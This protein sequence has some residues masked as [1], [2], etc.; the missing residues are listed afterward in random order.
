MQIKIGND[1]VYIPKFKK[2]IERTPNITEKIFH[3]SEKQDNRIETLAGIF[4]AKESVIK[5]LDLEA[6]VWKD[7]EIAKNS[8]GRPILTIKHY[9]LNI[10]SSDISISHDGDYAFATSV[11]LVE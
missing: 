11:F 5:A 9:Q 1:L 10:I 6:G 3:E 4:A 8:T 7:I 2:I